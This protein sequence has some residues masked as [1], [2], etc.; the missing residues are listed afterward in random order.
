VMA[1]PAL[2]ALS[3]GDKLKIELTTPAYLDVR[4]H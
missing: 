4:M 1:N 3:Y 2:A